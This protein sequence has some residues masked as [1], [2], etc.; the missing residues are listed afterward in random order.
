MTVGI[1]E[2]ENKID[3]EGQYSR[4]NCIFIHGAVENK[5]K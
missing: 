4:R 5:E 2:L 1:K 3:R